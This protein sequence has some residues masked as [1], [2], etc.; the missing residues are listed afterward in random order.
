MNEKKAGYSRLLEL[1]ALF[2][3]RRSN[4][5]L[6]LYQFNI[7]HWCIITLTEPKFQYTNVT[8]RPLHKSRTKVVKQFDYH[9]PIAETIKG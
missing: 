2:S 8:T 1:I 5:G 9:V 4:T 7:S 3:Y 6:T